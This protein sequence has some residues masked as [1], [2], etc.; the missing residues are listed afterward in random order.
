M[1]RAV[2]A[3][4]VTVVA[5]TVPLNVGL[6]VSATVPLVLGSVSVVSVAAAPDVRVTDPPPVPLTATGI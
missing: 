5:V 3:G 6:A 1:V 2:D 4:L